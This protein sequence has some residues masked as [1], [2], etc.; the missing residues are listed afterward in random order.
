SRGPGSSGSGSGGSGSSAPGSSS[1]GGRGKYQDVLVDLVDRIGDLADR[2]RD[3]PSSNQAARRRTAQLAEHV[4]R[5]VRPR[6]RG[7]DAPVL[8]LLV[9]PTGAGKSSLF[10]ALA[11]RNIS[12]TGVLRPTTRKL[13]AYAR[14]GDP[15]ELTAEGGPLAGIDRQR[16][17]IAEDASARDGV[18]LVDAP[19]VDSVEHAN[20]EL[21]DRLVEAADLAVFVTTATR[22]ADRVPWE[23][24]GRVGDRGLP[25]VVLV[26][27][28]PADPE[29]RTVVLDDFRRLL[30]DAGLEGRTEIDLVGVEEGALEAKIDGLDRKAV[31]PL[32]D[33][34]DGLAKHREARLELASR[35]LAGSLANLEPQLRTISEDLE[36]AAID[37]DRLRRLATEAFERELGVL[38]DELARGSFLRAEALRA[39]QDFVGADEI[40]KAFSSGIGKVRSSV[41]QLFRAAPTAPVA[42]VREQ[43]IADLRALAHVRVTEAIRRAAAAWSEEP[44]ARA[45]LDEDPA[46][47]SPAEDLDARIGVGLDQWLAAIGEDVRRT[48]GP[49]RT[50]AQGASVGVNAAGIGVML[51]TFSHTGGLTGAEV[52]IAAITGFLNQRLLS[53]LFG[54]AALVEMISRARFRLIETLGEAFRGEL[55]RFDARV[56]APDRL[57]GLSAETRSMADEL[58]TLPPAV[59]VSA[60]PVMMP[61]PPRLTLAD[62][63]ADAE[64]RQG[65]ASAPRVRPRWSIGR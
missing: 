59:S 43:T 54:E 41:T 28:M 1:S 63:E 45:I 36:H 18:V 6:A 24:L 53:A 7:L 42:E 33:R 61:V 48:G 3:V 14:P 9:G 13:V 17:L 65:I 5:H 46:A 10:N 44:A 31:H 21:T 12:A 19:D 4:V 50:L 51:A 58:R 56:P 62:E 32:I 11:S 37:S 27:R 40:T 38:R 29:E 64:R 15:E 35:A 55:A 49:K 60:R 23:V 26:N 25:L 52:G 39:W 22:Y 57:R 8:I 30:R 47:W 20:R 34:I 16:I 2:A